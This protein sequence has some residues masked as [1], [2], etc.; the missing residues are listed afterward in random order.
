MSARRREI[1]LRSRRPPPR[2]TKT[3]TNSLRKMFN[4]LSNS[5]RNS[6]PRQ[7]RLQNA[8]PTT[9]TD[10]PIETALTMSRT[11]TQSTM[12]PSKIKTVAALTTTPLTMSGMIQT[13]HTGWREPFPSREMPP[14]RLT[15]HWHHIWAR[16][17][18]PTI[19]WGGLFERQPV[20]ATGRPRRNAA[21]YG[22]P[23]DTGYFDKLSKGELPG[24]SFYSGHLVEPAPPQRTIEMALSSMK[25]DN[26][27]SQYRDPQIPK[28]YR[29]AVR[30]S[31]FESYWLPAMRKQDVS[32]QEK[33]VYDL[34][35]K[36]IGMTILPSKWVFDQK[37]DLDTGVT[38][39]RA[40]W[41]VCGNFEQGAWNSQDVYAAVINSVTVK[42]FFA[43][44]ATMDLE[45]RQFDFKTAFLNADIP[46]GVEYF[47]EPPAG[48]DKPLNKA[49]R[50]KKAL[51][52]L[53]HSPLYWFMTIKPIL[54]GMGFRSL[55]SDI[56]LFKHDELGILLVLYV[57]DLLI[58]AL[59]NGL[60]DWVRD[61][62]L[63]IFELKELGEV[64]RFLGFDVVRDRKNY[65]IFIS[66]ESYLR[67]FLDKKNMTDCSSTATPW[68]SK[69]ELPTE[70][71]PIA[72]QQKAYIKDTGSLNW[73]STGTRPDIAY[74]AS[75]LAEANNGPSLAHLD[76]LKHLCRYLNGS[77]SRGLEFGGRGL[78]IDD[79]KFQTFAD[80]S[81]ADRLPSRHSTGG[82][83]VFVAGGP[84]FWK[85]KKQTFVA[86]STTEAEFANLTPA[87]LSTKWVARIL[88]EC[89]APQPKPSILHTDSLNAH[90]TVMNPMNKA[91]T[92]TIDIRYKWIIEQTQQGHIDVKHLKGVNMAADG[93]TKPL[94][95][96]KHELFCGMM[97]MVEKRIPWVG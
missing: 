80:A 10:N 63:E 93:L 73:M 33:D 27:I 56:C 23:S 37:K 14:F 36:R 68:P 52:G 89:G 40:R 54:E 11:N 75:R 88:E 87:G 86:L 50:L 95:R 22:N 78:S 39:P 9:R 3:L 31:N 74:T 43:L 53:R 59:N 72:G 49:C 47:V 70:W 45:C 28:N 1:R 30:E 41:V 79:L 97:G 96:E 64:K 61:R 62:L 82:H 13:M 20:T 48:L 4:N 35:D 91:R 7:R 65:K 76:L 21:R 55:E 18:A 26:D 71:E 77:V 81:L 32:L 84:V 19:L 24:Q 44:V 5:L 85:T 69:F 6:C 29:Q 83:A 8:N 94:T 57:D 34:V 42:T 51:Y 60:I 66:Q 17:L 15:I 12:S 92:R 90:L 58:A 16:L 38:I 67:S 2:I 25:V 46:D